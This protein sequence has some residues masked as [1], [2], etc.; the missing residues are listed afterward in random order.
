MFI[1]CA[2]GDST[3]EVDEA[4]FLNRV[5]LADRMKW[6]LDYIDSLDA[7]EYR[8]LLTMLEAVDK[9]AQFRAERRGG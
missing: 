9:A 6:T 1:A 5:L 4:E 2:M 8:Q 3:L 7:G